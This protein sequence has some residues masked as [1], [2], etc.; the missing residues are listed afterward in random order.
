M[1]IKHNSRTKSF[2]FGLNL[3]NYRL[4]RKEIAMG[5]SDNL[6]KITHNN[7]L[8]VQGNVIISEPFLKDAYFQRSVVLLVEHAKEGTIGLVLNKKTSLKVNSFFDEL[9]DCPDM[10]IYIGGP[11]SPTRLFFIHTLGDKLISGSVKI[12]DSLYFDGSFN[13]LKD[14]ILRGH[15][16]EGKVKFF[17]GYSGWTKGQLSEEIRQDSWLVSSEPS[18]IMHADGDDYWK[19]S[20]SKLGKIYRNWIIYPKDPCLN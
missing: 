13:E 2:F 14:Y 3:L 19:S 5:L 18:D 11:V 9:K 4:I 1:L 20:V 7:V 8:P 15:T 17:L 12:K 6:F 16:I 10:P